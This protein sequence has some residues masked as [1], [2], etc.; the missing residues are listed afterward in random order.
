MTTTSSFMSIS[1]AD[2][3]WEIVARSWTVICASRLL[4]RSI[5]TMSQAGPPVYYAMVSMCSGPHHAAVGDTFVQ[6]QPTP[7]KF[8]VEE[9]AH[10]IYLLGFFISVSLADIALTVKKEIAKFKVADF[11]I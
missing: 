1:P 9:L 11:A 8:A 6:D 2:V 5:G 10:N 7:L 3:F 4:D